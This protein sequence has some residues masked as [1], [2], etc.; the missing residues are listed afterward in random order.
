MLD[1]ET[2]SDAL[3]RELQREGLLE[4]RGGEWRSTAR[5]MGAMSRAALSLLTA[6]EAGEDLRVPI[7]LALVSVYGTDASDARLAALVETM[8]PIEQRELCPPP[9]H[10]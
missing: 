2:T 3:R 10:R 7:A 4:Q 9:A 1:H 6:G 8:L 5:W